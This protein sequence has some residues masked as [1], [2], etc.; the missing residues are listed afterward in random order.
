M[1]SPRPPAATR[2]APR[3]RAASRA[4]RVE[5]R[6]FVTAAV[7]LAA[8]LAVFVTSPAWHDHADGHAC[9][10]DAKAAEVA[11]CGHGHG[12]GH[13]AHEHGTEPVHPIGGHDCELCDLTA[14]C[15]LPVTPPAVADAGGPRPD[16]VRPVDE[17]AE[18]RFL[19]TSS[20]RGPPRA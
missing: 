1:P 18:P 19:R 8:Y 4:V 17:G 7:G 3:R 13:G 2:P 11:D 5:R 12:E 15:P 6:Q 10:G 9:G 14:Q 16:P 20:A